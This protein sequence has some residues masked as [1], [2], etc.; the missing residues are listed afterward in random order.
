MPTT[1]ERPATTGGTPSGSSAVSGTIPTGIRG[2]VT[3][4]VCG[5]M[6]TVVSVREVADDGT[7]SISF[8]IGESE[9]KFATG[10]SGF[11]AYESCNVTIGDDGFHY[12]QIYKF[13]S[14]ITYTAMP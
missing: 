12:A 3:E 11:D 6:P 10:A 9:I 5:F 2:E 13:A 14:V 1:F 7:V 4:V 8:R